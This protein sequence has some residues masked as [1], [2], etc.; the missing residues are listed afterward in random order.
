MAEKLFTA[1]ILIIRVLDPACAKFLVGQVVGILEDM[2]TCH[3]P[4]RQGGMTRLVGVILT[5]FV[6]QEL[7]V[8]PVSQHHLFMAHVNDLVEP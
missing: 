4:R 5:A 8:D 6:R 3:Q 7:P 1:E 2:K